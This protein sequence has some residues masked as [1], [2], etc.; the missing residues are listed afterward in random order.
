MLIFVKI[1]SCLRLPWPPKPRKTFYFIT[2]STALPLGGADE[3]RSY[4]DS[5]S[6]ASASSKI[7]NF[8]K[9]TLNKSDD[10]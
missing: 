10:F 5:G 7:F 2:V 3:V 6:P 4:L 1:F 8:L 9:I